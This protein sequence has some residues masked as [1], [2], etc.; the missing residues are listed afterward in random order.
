[1]KFLIEPHTCAGQL[2]LRYGENLSGDRVIQ[3]LRF[4]HLSYQAKRAELFDWAAQTA[5]AF[6]KA[7]EL[8]TPTLFDEFISL[9]DKKIVNRDGEP[10]RIQNRVLCLMLFTKHPEL[11]I[12]GDIEIMEKFGNV[13][14]KYFFF[15][16]TDFLR[17][18]CVDRRAAKKNSLASMT[19]K[20]FLSLLYA[21]YPALAVDDSLLEG[22]DTISLRQFLN[23][24]VPDDDSTLSV[25]VEEFLLNDPDADSL[26]ISVSKADSVSDD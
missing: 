5:E 9:R 14:M 21:E 1:M 18:I 4:L 24:A 11:C 10:F 6:V 23:D 17:N 19:L 3:I 25:P 22:L 13:H 2:N 16:V 15:D 26:L 20:D 7:L 12:A 8:R